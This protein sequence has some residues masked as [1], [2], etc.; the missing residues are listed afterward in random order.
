M[1]KIQYDALLSAIVKQTTTLT[2]LNQNINTLITKV[3]SLMDKT[4][5]ITDTDIGK[6]LAALQVEIDSI[7]DEQGV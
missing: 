5:L 2:L 1:N 4:M 7:K 6:Q 3:Q